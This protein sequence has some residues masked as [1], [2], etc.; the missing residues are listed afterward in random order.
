MYHAE[1][2]PTRMRW[3][4]LHHWVSLAIGVSLRS[5]AIRQ[6]PSNQL[7]MTRVPMALD[8]LKPQSAAVEIT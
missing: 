5:G 4:N 1:A 6:Q 2:E 3:Q 8:I 7:H